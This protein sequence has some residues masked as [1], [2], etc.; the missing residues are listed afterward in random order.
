MLVTVRVFIPDRVIAGQEGIGLDQQIIKI[1]QI[2]LQFLPVIGLIDVRHLEHG[3]VLVI[4][5]PE[6]FH[7][8]HIVFGQANLP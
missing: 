5:A 4:E 1:Q 7:G 2:L 6:F 8:D 3:L